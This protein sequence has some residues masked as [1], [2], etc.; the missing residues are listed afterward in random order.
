MTTPRV[1]GLYQR[2]T[3]QH[4]YWQVTHFLLAPVVTDWRGISL[5]RLL[6]IAGGAVVPLFDGLVLRNRPSGTDLWFFIAGVS[7][8]M[9]EKVWLSFLSRNTNTSSSK[10]ETE[11]KVTVDVAKILEARHGKDHESTP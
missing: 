7:A 5:V 1:S 2:A 6:A 11:T 4:W 9:G 3:D 10:D 8:A